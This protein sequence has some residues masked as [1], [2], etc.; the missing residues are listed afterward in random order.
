MLPSF[1]VCTVHNA[2]Q[3]LPYC[4]LSAYPAVYYKDEQYCIDKVI[5]PWINRGIK[6]V[7]SLL[8]D[9]EAHVGLV[10]YKPL[11]ERLA[12]EQVQFHRLAIAD[13]KTTTDALVIELIEQIELWITNK[14]STLIHCM[15]GR[16]RSHTIGAILVGRALHLDWKDLL[17]YL[18]RCIIKREKAAIRYRAKNPLSQLE[19]RRQ[20]QRI[21]YNIVAD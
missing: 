14:E 18:D 6:H 5:Q 15:M 7:V 1:P 11:F 19:Q 3:I 20:V 13:T 8:D 16:G 9:D 10:D 4:Y 17:E 12:P 21:L 2:H